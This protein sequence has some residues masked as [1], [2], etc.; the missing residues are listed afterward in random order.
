[1]SAL[2][3]T[4]SAD[5]VNPLLRVRCGVC[6]EEVCFQNVQANSHELFQSLLE[7]KGWHLYPGIRCPECVNKRARK[8]LEEL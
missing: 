3:T 5:L 8:F 2:V 1:M 6:R 4:Q 7:K